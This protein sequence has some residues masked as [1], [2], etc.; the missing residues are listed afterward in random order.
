MQ[1]EF[2]RRAPR[3]GR[4][5]IS[6]PIKRRRVLNIPAL[7]RKPAGDFLSAFRKAALVGPPADSGQLQFRCATHA[8]RYRAR[9]LASSS[10]TTGALVLANVERGCVVRLRRRANTVILITGMQEIDIGA[11]AAIISQDAVDSGSHRTS[12]GNRSEENCLSR[13]HF[14]GPRHFDMA[15][16]AKAAA[17]FRDA[18]DACAVSILRHDDVP[19]Q[20][21]LG[22]LFT[23]SPLYFRTYRI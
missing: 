3:F 15:C 10:P 14:S 12:A 6:P 7:L 23:N 5:K 17:S 8:R 21:L 11:I 9:N 16:V 2:C 13:T 18:L 1:A 20:N 4:Q 19:R 22:S